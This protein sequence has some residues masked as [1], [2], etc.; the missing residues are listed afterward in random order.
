MLVA[1]LDFLQLLVIKGSLAYL[2][3]QTSRA[4]RAIKHSV[5]ASTPD[6]ARTVFDSRWR[7]RMPSRMSTCVF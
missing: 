6:E 3:K 5:D 7:T 4:W 2:A 1:K